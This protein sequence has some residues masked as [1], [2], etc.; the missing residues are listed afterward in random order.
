LQLSAL[1]WVGYSSADKIITS[2]WQ[3]CVQT[4]SDFI[5]SH[6]LKGLSNLILISVAESC[7]MKLPLDIVERV[8]CEVT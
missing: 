1:V 2:L 3:L 7:Y 4:L 8:W 5:L 6:S